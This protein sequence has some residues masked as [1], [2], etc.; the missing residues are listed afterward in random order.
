MKLE[1]NVNSG[2]PLPLQHAYCRACCAMALA[3][4]FTL[5]VKRVADTGIEEANA[6]EVLWALPAMA[7]PSVRLG[8]S[9]EDAFGRDLDR[10]DLQA[11]PWAGRLAE[12]VLGM[13][14]LVRLRW[15]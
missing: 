3:P 15:F 6:A 10:G 4:T 8:A 7:R 9:I 11:R 12:L 2:Q 14:L 1:D 13:E 5:L